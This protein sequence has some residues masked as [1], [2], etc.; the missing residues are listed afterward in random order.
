[1]D[2]TG[3]YFL[4]FRPVLSSTSNADVSQGLKAPPPPEDDPLPLL[5]DDEDDELLEE[6]E[7]ELLDEDELELAVKVIVVTAPVVRA[8]LR[9]AAL[10]VSAT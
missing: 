10:P 8:I 3:V 6:L 5:L 2:Q 4:N 7:E 9:I 1:M